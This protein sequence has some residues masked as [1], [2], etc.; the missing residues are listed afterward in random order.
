MTDPAAAREA[1]TPERKRPG[2][3][4]YPDFALDGRGSPSRYGHFQSG[5][6]LN[7]YSA[8][9]ELRATLDTYLDAGTRAWAE[10]VLTEL[11]EPAG[12]ELARRADVYDVAGHELARYDRFGRDVSQIAYHPDW[13]TRSRPRSPVA[14]TW[15][16]P[17]PRPSAGTTAHGR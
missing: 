8:D 14:A 2:L 13:L 9:P 15:A 16:P 5:R 12:T 11:G 3:P 1:P 7:Y 6:G 4:V 10:D 17:A